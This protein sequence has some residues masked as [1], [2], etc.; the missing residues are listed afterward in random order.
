MDGQE[1]R[2]G[3][4]RIKLCGVQGCCPTVEFD[5]QGNVVIR[6]DDGGQVKLNSDQQEHFARIVTERRTAR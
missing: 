2:P 6:D 1:V 3:A 5:S 4:S